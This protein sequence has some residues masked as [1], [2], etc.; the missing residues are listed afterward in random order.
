MEMSGRDGLG[1]SVAI[2][3]GAI[4]GTMGVLGLPLFMALGPQVYENPRPR[5]LNPL[6]NGPIVGKRVST[7]LPLA[8]LDK[9]VL[10]DPAVVAQLNERTRQAKPARHVVAHQPVRR[11][12]AAAVAEL[13]QRSGFSLF[14]LFGG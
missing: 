4:V 7:P 6:L 3:M 10:V 2:Y 13:P 1:F 12:R 8:L 9:P 5:P 11:E 14:N